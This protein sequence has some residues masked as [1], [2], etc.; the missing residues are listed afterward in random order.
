MADS[1]FH[2]EIEESETE[3]TRA[4]RF[5]E[6]V[7]PAEFGW[8]DVVSSTI[9][10][11]LVSWGDR[12]G[13]SRPIMGQ[14]FDQLQP[15][16]FNAIKTDLFK[17]SLDRSLETNRFLELNDERPGFVKRPSYFATTQAGLNEMIEWARNWTGAAVGIQLDAS[18]GSSGGRSGSRKPTAEEIRNQFDV[19]QLA[20]QVNDL[21]RALVLEE[22]ADPMKVARQYVDA[23]VS[24][25]GEKKIDFVTFVRDKIEATS[26][27]K[28]IY[29]SK[30]EHVKAE[31]YIAP[32]LQQAMGFGRPEEAAELAIGGAQFGASAQQFQE[33]LKRTDS[34]TSSA[35]FI[36]NLEGR[37]GEL[38]SIFKG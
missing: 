11:D 21:N 22:H 31:L 17:N 12:N 33:R 18:R 4:Q 9:L 19:K 37:L 13:Q 32:Y 15:H 14:L 36:A 30:P 1:V 38:S 7:E 27:F 8:V 3:K 24:T 23:I 10:K 29:R 35:P 16:L 28:S 25:G 26:R 34:F 5:E 20:E 6:K 2:T